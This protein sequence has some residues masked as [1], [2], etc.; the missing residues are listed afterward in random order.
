MSRLR[1]LAVLI[2]AATSV[3]AADDP[4]SITFP[5]K[6][7]D[8]VREKPVQLSPDGPLLHLVFLA[9]W[10]PPC[11][12]EIP[13]LSELDARWQE[14]GYRLVLVAVPTRQTPARLRDF[15][16]TEDPPG[17]LL[18]DLYGLGLRESKTGQIPQHLLVAADGTVLLRADSLDDGVEEAVET[19]MESRA[20]GDG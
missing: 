3:V 9:T 15:I 14:S 7:S 5:V 2:A 16:E 1:A 17:T 13:R 19:F 10:C 6:L 11:M 20:R 4:G 18:L 8:P 12:D